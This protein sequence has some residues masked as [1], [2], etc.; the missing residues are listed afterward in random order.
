MR[1]DLGKEP[2]GICLMS[3]LLLGSRDLDGA[4]RVPERLFSTPHEQDSLSQIRQPQ[5]VAV[6]R[7]RRVALLYRFGQERHRLVEATTEQISIANRRRDRRGPDL[8]I[9]EPVS[10]TA[11]LGE[12]DGLRD[13]ALAHMKPTGGKARQHQLERIFVR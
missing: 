4:T 13:I 11:L 7:L 6:H 2:E 1:S 3:P 5:G 8:K 10:L 9:A 12:L